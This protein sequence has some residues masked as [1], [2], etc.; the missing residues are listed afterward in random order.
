[1]SQDV[2]LAHPCNHLVIEEVV[3]LASDRRSL[4][5]RCPVSSANAVRVLANDA[6]YIPSMGLGSQAQLVGAFGGPFN[7]GVCDR[8]LTVTTGAGRVSLTLP[9][10]SNSAVQ[11]ARTL[12]GLLPD[13]AV[14]VTLDGKLVLTDT[15][16]IGRA[17]LITVGG[18]AAASLG[19][20]YQR[21]AR[22]HDVYPGWSNVDDGSG[23]GRQPMFRSPIMGNPMLKVT[24]PT[25]PS[26]CLRCG[27]TYVENDVRFN[28]QGDVVLIEGANLLY[29]A[30]MKILLTRIQSNPYHPSYGSALTSRVGA[31]AIG[32]TTTLLT[33]D[34]TRALA[35]MQNLQG[36]QAKYQSVSREERLYSVTTVRVTP[37]P[38]DQTAFQVYV[39]LT[40]ASGAPVEVSI[41]F[42]VPG[43]IALA[44]TNRL[45]LGLEPTGL[46]PTD[47]PG[48]FR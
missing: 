10:G 14:E 2:L 44:G 11:V 48:L 22:G 12:T 39:V 6:Y 35:A 30:A 20:Q 34:V 24:Y 16:S 13:T 31:K 25:I 36:M 42:T 46:S 27:G 26:R 41:V 29:Q 4:P 33:E 28:S 23:V 38:A 5:T 7:V 3:A 1:M 18:G 8:D 47:I 9:S 21:G 40:N 32:A 15:A 19:F 43:V 45:T 17:S 37:H